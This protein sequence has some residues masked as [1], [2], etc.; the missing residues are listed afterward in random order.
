MCA[1]VGALFLFLN[2]RKNHILLRSFFR[3]FVC[4]PLCNALTLVI[5][6]SA[7]NGFVAAL[8]MIAP[9][10]LLRGFALCVKI[11]KPDFERD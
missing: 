11:G 3:R 6:V 1:G 4:V 10:G 5:L 7:V 2:G 9:P 8:V